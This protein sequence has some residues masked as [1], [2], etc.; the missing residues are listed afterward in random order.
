MC[1][2]SV[3]FLLIALKGTVAVTYI[4]VQDTSSAV[5]IEPLPCWFQY[6][7]VIIVVQQC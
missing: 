6:H 4:S 1:S 2:L 5:E 3:T 7:P